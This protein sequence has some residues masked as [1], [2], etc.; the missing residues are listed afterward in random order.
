MHDD[1]SDSQDFH[2]ITLMWDSMDLRVMPVNRD[3]IVE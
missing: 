2:H 3:T 1:R